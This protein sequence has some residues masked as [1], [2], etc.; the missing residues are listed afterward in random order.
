MPTELL[1][2]YS[3]SNIKIAVRSTHV[4]FLH[5]D[6]GYE[7]K[8]RIPTL[9]EPYIMYN[10]VAMRLYL[11]NYWSSVSLKNTVIVNSVLDS[12][13]THIPLSSVCEQEENHYICNPSNVVIRHSQSSCELDIVQ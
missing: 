2:H 4:E 10:L 1:Q 5:S 11:E 13:E 3:V 8:L 6:K 12:L 9:S 7:M